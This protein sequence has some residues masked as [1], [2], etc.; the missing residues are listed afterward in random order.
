M[1]TARLVL[2]GHLLLLPGLRLGAQTRESDTAVL[3]GDEGGGTA[4]STGT[5]FMRIGSRNVTLEYSKPYRQINFGRDCNRPGALWRIEYRLKPATRDLF[6]LESANCIGV[7]SSV[8]GAEQV[9]RQYYEELSHKRF[10]EAFGLLA[11]PRNVSPKTREVIR[12]DREAALTS[13]LK[14]GAPVRCVQVECVSEKA[15]ALVWADDGCFM[16]NARP[17]GRTFL[18]EWTDGV[19]KI[20]DMGRSDSLASRKCDSPP[21]HLIDP[22]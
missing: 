1:K 10:N 2:V 11:S 15:L 9:V 17:I 7:R 3:L 16:E 20:R 6:V 8:R 4:T 12:E 21:R 14:F 19:W 22:Q 5:V 13:Y 18:L